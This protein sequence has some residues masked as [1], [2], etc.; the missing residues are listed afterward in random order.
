MTDQGLGLASSTDSNSKSFRERF[1]PEVLLDDEHYTIRIHGDLSPDAKQRF[2]K[3]LV[4][5]LHTSTGLHK[6][7]EIFHVTRAHAVKPVRVNK[8]TL[9][10]P[11]AKE[12]NDNSV[13][14]AVEKL[15]EA[16]A[17]GIFA[18]QMQE[19]ISGRLRSD[20][21][22]DI[23]GVKDPSDILGCADDRGA[24]WVHV[25]KYHPSFDPY[26]EL[27]LIKDCFRPGAGFPGHRFS[28]LT[29]AMGG[30]DKFLDVLAVAG[31]NFLRWIKRRC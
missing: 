11:E 22:C 13:D 17:N 9:I 30:V 7:E 1:P 5:I 4:S 16:Y 15:D 24:G 29:S 25:L 21:V 23:L 19:Q 18:N 3:G 12:V 14:I 28:E 2:A 10:L 27:P 31:K 26:R 8:T 6:F 20:V